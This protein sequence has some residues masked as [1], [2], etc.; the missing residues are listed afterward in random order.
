MAKKKKTITTH[1]PI[2]VS[3]LKREQ[4][5][6]LRR[7]DAQRSTAFKIGGVSS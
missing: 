2:V 6:I 3:S 4:V 7:V 5:H 1:D